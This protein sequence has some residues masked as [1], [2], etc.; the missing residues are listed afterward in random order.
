LP[1]D[2]TNGLFTTEEIALFVT[3]STLVVATVTAC[4]AAV[5]EC[6]DFDL[7]RDPLTAPSALTFELFTPAFVQ[8]AAALVIPPIEVAED[9]VAPLPIAVAAADVIAL[10]IAVVVLLLF[11]GPFDPTVF[12]FFSFGTML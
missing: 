7:V 2:T 12:V 11:F 3:A 9:D 6:G 1:L 10:P 4:C 5:E 8:V